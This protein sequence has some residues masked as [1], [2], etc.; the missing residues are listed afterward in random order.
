MLTAAIK[1][2]GV[3]MCEPLG[4]GGSALRL[5]VGSQGYVQ[6]LGAFIYRYLPRGPFGCTPGSFLSLRLNHRAI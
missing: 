6:K 5:E 2:A 1:R 3:R 4:P